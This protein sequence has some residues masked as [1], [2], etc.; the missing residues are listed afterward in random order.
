MPCLTGVSGL[1]RLHPLTIRFGAV[2]PGPHKQSLERAVSWASRRWGLTSLVGPAF[3]SLTD[4]STADAG[5][6]TLTSG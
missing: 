2:V 4:S 5:Y 6:S 3:E 1:V